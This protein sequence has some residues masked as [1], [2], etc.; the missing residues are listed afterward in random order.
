[1]MA[2]MTALEPV[3]TEQLA[4]QVEIIELQKAEMPAIVMP[5]K[6]LLV[7]AAVE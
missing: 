6:P 7:I 2:I 1:M 5:V 3:V 4:P